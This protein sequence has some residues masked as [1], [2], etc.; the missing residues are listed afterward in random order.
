MK[1]FANGFARLVFGLCMVMTAPAWAEE[2]YA[3]I[4]NPTNEGKK[5]EPAKPK[6][7]P[8]VCSQYKLTADKFLDAFHAIAMHGDLTDVA[9]IEKTLQTKFEVEYSDRED[10]HNHKYKRAFYTGKSMF[11]APIY[12]RLS[13]DV[14]REPEMDFPSGAQIDISSRRDI[15][16]ISECLAFSAGDFKQKFEKEF[17]GVFI[18]HSSSH[19]AY[20]S[21]DTTL[22]MPGKSASKMT[23]G[24]T[25]NT[26]EQIIIDVG[27]GQR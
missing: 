4:E 23:V 2:T 25:R 13:F 6:K 20:K 17:K 3:F 26:E 11:D 18:E 1:K 12:V 15:N 16:F 22:I 9:F 5:I 24:Y 10:K 21:G 19:G 27:M 14:E 7:K 8:P